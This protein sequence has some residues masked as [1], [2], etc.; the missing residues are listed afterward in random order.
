MLMQLKLR[1]NQAIYYSG[2][3]YNEMKKVNQSN[4]INR[5][6]NI[7]IRYCN[8]LEN[9]ESYHLTKVKAYNV[10]IAPH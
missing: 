10:A 3:I 2:Q 8:Q 9:C 4:P 5:Y 6:T 7:V 1:L